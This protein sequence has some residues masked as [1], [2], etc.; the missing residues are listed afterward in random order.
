[1]KPGEGTERVQILLITGPAGVGKST[2]CWELSARLAARG[3]A[4]GAIEGDEL[5]RIYPLPTDDEL[6]SL[7]PGATDV[8]EINLA[9]IWSTYRALGRKR[10]ILSGVML[11][12]EEDRLWIGAAI[13]G[14]EI[15]VVRLRCTVPTLLS[16]LDRREVGS[17]R[18]DQIR[19]SLQQAEEMHDQA[20][21]GLIV[22][23]T[24]GATPMELADRVLQ[25]I[26]WLDDD[27]DARAG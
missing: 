14:A 21:G 26:D 3:I 13:P 19:R 6:A 18:D 20:D 15:I 8:S 23:E 11:R 1:M 5:D 25:A 22:V 16:R 12:P 10:L 17:G 24:D 9:A 27:G 2:L 7:R 4:H